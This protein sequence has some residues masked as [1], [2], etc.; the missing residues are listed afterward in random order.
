MSLHLKL[1][2][3]YLQ[4]THLHDIA[5]ILQ[6]DVDWAKSNLCGSSRCTKSAS[7]VW[8]GK[9]YIFLYKVYSSVAPFPLRPLAGDP[10]L[11]TPAAAPAQALH[12]LPARDLWVLRGD[13]DLPLP[14]LLLQDGV[15]GRGL[16]AAV[17]LR[18]HE[19]LQVGWRSVTVC[20]TRRHKQTRI[21]WHPIWVKMRCHHIFVCLF[22]YWRSTLIM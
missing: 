2:G 15:R 11:P 4:S 7:E 19:H 12:V 17:R 18:L 9:S 22:I 20:A 21:W 5:L 16:R 3:V 10:L 13:T 6:A 14:L 8:G 1:T